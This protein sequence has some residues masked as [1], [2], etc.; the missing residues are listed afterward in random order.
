MLTI[1]GM[2][3]LYAF[4]GL[5]VGFMI[6]AAFLGKKHDLMRDLVL[7]LAHRLDDLLTQSDRGKS[8][9][10]CKDQYKASIVLMHDAERLLDCQEFSS[11]VRTTPF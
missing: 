5:A 10:F 6:A 4:G 8:V 3:A 1:T 2:Q 9:K 7:G 11:T